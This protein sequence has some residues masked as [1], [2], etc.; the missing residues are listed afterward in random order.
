METGGRGSDFKFLDSYLP[1]APL[2]IMLESKPA[3]APLRGRSSA[4]GA[5]SGTGAV[6]GRLGVPGRE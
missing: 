5:S 4:A 3:S 2:P 1:N 6:G